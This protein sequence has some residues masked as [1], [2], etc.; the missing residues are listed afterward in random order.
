MRLSELKN[1]GRAPSLPLTI[2]LADAAGPADLQLLSL[3]F[4]PAQM[5]GLLA[6][7]N[8]APAGSEEKLAILRVM[9]MLDDAS[10]RN[11]ELVA[12]YMASRWQKAFPGQGAVQEQ[13]MGHLDYALDLHRRARAGNRQCAEEEGHPCPACHQVDHAPDGRHDL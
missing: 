10:G 6:D 5:Q 1:A 7:L 2:S 4:L 8:Q 9:R 3:R 12:Q 13:L 11:K